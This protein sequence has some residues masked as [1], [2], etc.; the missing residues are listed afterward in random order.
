MRSSR[1]I[2]LILWAAAYA[3]T[4]ALAD[5]TVLPGKN[6]P[7]VPA[8]LSFELDIQPIL[9]AR[10][11][12]QGACHGKARGQNG[13]QLSLL[14]F[15]A[16]FDHAALT[17]NARG[18]RVFLAAPERSLVL[19][20]ATAQLPHGGGV[21][22]EKESDD[23]HAMLR[24]IAEGAARRLEGEQKLVAI[25]V[26]R[27]S[28]EGNTT[29]GTAHPTEME[30]FLRPGEELPLTVTATYSDGSQREATSLSQFQSSEAGIVGVSAA[31]LVKAGPIP[32]EATIMARYMTLIA[33]CHI[34]IPLA[35]NVPDEQYTA[36]PRRNFIDEH[37]WT[38]LR[39]LG[40][41]PSAPCDDAKF[42]RRAHLDIIGR[43]PS[44]EEVRKFVAS[45]DSQK[46][47]RLVDEL[48]ER[49]EYAD[50]WTAKWADLLR[51]NPYRVGIKA[52][53]NYDAWIRDSFR[54]NKPYD[55]FVRELVTA[56]G[57]TWENGASVLFRDRRDPTEIATLVSQLFLGIRLECAKCHHHPFEKY[58][59]DDFYGFAANFARLGH[60]GTGLSPPISGS[61]E[62][63]MLR[64]SGTVEHPLTHAAMPPRPLFGELPQAATDADPRKALAEWMTSEENPFFAKVIAN[65]VWSDLMGRGLVEPVD[66][67]RATNPP[68]NGPL[69]DAL[70]ADFRA[71]RCDI[72]KLIR[73]ICTSHAY[74][75]SSLPGDR[76]V[77]DRQN[78]SRHF[79][80][81]LRGEVL[82]DA[83]TD[84]TGVAENFAAMPAGARANQLWTT[85]VQSVF[86][87]TFGRPNPNQDPPCERL[88]DTTVTQ[89]LHLMNAPQLHQRVTS[90]EGNA[91]LLAASDRSADEIVE[92][93]YLLAYSRMPDDAERTIGRELFAENGTSRRQ[94]TEDLMWAL[95]NTPEFMFKD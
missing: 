66:D 88:S 40:I 3:G 29:V 77:V 8:P 23:Y 34:A 26:G 19:L 32:G 76:N 16:D 7:R 63:V 71:N 35:G 53:F 49:P 86:L 62:I 31:G 42:L 92:E 61:E 79:R 57:S 38:K 4:Q 25:A 18:R 10:G 94:A 5:E 22:I 81:R 82:L 37:V 47:S 27:S 84:I 59:Q 70:A 68:T 21:R 78:Y 58:G 9:T 15:D 55:Q 33:T 14:G 46:R 6:G 56:E 43:L 69:L 36:L 50:H 89:T 48:L 72:K 51:P 93:I 17:Q 20:K 87:D 74:G 1:L 28:S 67:L 11:C 45:E 39:S 54:Q 65:R 13:F 80:T 24:W 83:V 60:K 41:T 12:N 91:A 90:S 52:V 75:L 85:R 30:A 64:K 95:M 2:A 73:A 44:P